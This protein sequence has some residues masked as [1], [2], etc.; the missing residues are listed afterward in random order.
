M[1]TEDTSPRT[2]YASFAQSLW[3][4]LLSHSPFSRTQPAW[5]RFLGIAYG[6]FISSSFHMMALHRIGHVFHRIGFVPV[7]LLIEKAIYHLYHCDIPCSA[8]IG[9]GVWF[10]HPLGI[11]IAQRTQIG[12]RVYIFQQVQLISSPSSSKAYNKTIKIGD[13]CYL[14]AGATIIG[15][16]VGEE[17]MVAAQSVVTKTVPPRHMAMGIPATVKPLRQ[18][19]LAFLPSEFPGGPPGVNP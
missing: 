3:K 2:T 19:Q 18:E 6:I 1:D 13:R 4:D 16:C 14:M 9:P 17:S 5:R 15:S 8:K 11:V 7:C 10:A 12:S